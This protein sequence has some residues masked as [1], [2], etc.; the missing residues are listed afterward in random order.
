M[1]TKHMNKNKAVSM[2]NKSIT[3]ATNTWQWNELKIGLKK[4][5]SGVCDCGHVTGCSGYREV[6]FGLA[7][8]EVAPNAP[9]LVMRQSWT[10]GQCTTYVDTNR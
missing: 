5:G 8:Q 3:N 2:T 1:K 6:Q 7:L 10:A 9:N 4:L